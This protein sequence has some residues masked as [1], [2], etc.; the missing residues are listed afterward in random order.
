MDSQ[1]ATPIGLHLGEIT[2]Y[3]R[4]YSGALPN[5]FEAEATISRH[6][7]LWFR[8]HI[9]VGELLI[10]A[11]DWLA[12][13]P[14]DMHQNFEYHSLDTEENPIFMLA[15]DPISGLYGCHS[16]CACFEDQ[17]DLTL[18]AVTSWI[19]TVQ[20]QLAGELNTRYGEVRIS[21]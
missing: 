11:R 7:R 20:E 17:A 8:E 18:E 4:D 14:S 16:A 13:P 15:Q 19:T 3:N 5:N 6:G 9:T 2:W 12:R 1:T 10:Q 21:W